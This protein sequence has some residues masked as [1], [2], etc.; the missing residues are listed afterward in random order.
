MIQKVN[1]QYDRKKVIRE[2][3][4]YL[5]FST[6]FLSIELFLTNR[7]ERDL[8]FIVDSVLVIYL[9]YVYIT[10]RYH[11]YSLPIDF[12][13]QSQKDKSRWFKLKL[14]RTVT[15]SAVLFNIVID[16][17]KYFNY[18]PGS[19]AFL[20]FGSISMFSITITMVVAVF[21]MIYQGAIVS[22]YFPA[23]LFPT[24]FIVIG[25]PIAYIGSLGILLTFVSF[26]ESEEGLYFKNKLPIPLSEVEK[27][28]MS[29]HNQNSLIELKRQ[30]GTTKIVTL[31]SVFIFSVVMA[32]TNN[33][34]LYALFKYLAKQDS[35]ANSKSRMAEIIVLRG[36]TRLAIFL[37]IITTYDI[38]K[39]FINKYRKHNGAIP[40]QMCN[41]RV[42]PIVTKARREYY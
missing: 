39:L 9:V 29:T 12:N 15:T 27:R 8:L 22:D 13:F 3:I 7:Y 42:Y 37:V 4:G 18:K 19:T 28:F 40:S 25:F 23:L 20:I 32:A 41:T 10:Y 31:V 30:W 38:L 1:K 35:L 33:D 24:L 26:Y 14:V 6:A 11:V 16:I 2:Q 36:F 5:L 21:R 34:K 17:L